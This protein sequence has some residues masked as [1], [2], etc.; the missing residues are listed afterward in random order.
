VE[1]VSWEA[2]MELCRRLSQRAKRVYSLPRE[3]QWEC[4]CRAGTT[5]PFASPR[6]RLEAMAQ[7]I[8]RSSGTRLWN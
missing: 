7:E 8:L 6:D 5:T 2:A 4:A 1:Q 3:A